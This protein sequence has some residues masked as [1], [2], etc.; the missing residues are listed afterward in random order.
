MDHEDW[1]CSNSVDNLTLRWV[2]VTAALCIC[3]TA[4]LYRVKNRIVTEAEP[5]YPSPGGQNILMAWCPLFHV[6]K[7][8]LTSKK[9]RLL[10]RLVKLIVGFPFLFC[11]LKP[12]FRGDII[13]FASVLLITI[14]M[15]GGYFAD[16]FGNLI[17]AFA[18]M[19]YC[20]CPSIQTSGFLR[21]NN[22]H[23]I[24][25]WPTCLW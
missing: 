13:C 23:M 21:G 12:D 2:S 9:G 8:W 14:E 24:P 6:R 16:I 22:S 18:E 25:V 20:F 3:E 10:F 11:Y 5:G 7:S 15:A 17:K 19:F 1:A 4:Y